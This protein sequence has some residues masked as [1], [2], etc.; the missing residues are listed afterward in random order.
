MIRRPPEFTRTDTLYPDTTLFRSGCEGAGLGVAHREEAP[1]GEDEGDRRHHWMILVGLRRQ[2]RGHEE[3]AVVLVE[4]RRNL[5][6]RHLVAGR[7]IDPQPR[8]DVDRKRT[9][10][11]SSH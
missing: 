6:L 9:R 7:H 5:D 10:L 4:A 3:R 11:N 8:F 1:A 2:V